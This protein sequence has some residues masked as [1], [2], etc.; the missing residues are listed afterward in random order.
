VSLSAVILLAPIVEGNPLAPS[1]SG[2]SLP[3]FGRGICF[4]RSAAAGFSLAR[5]VKASVCAAFPIF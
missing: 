4:S 5:L 2:V 1:A 3:A